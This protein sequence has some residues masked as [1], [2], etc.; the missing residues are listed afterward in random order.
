MNGFF[1]DVMG[2]PEINWGT[3]P[4]KI[5]TKTKTFQHGYYTEGEVIDETFMDVS[6]PQMLSEEEIKNKGF[7]QYADGEVYECF[8]LTEIPLN[9]NADSYRTVVF[10]NREYEIIKCSPF[11]VNYGTPQFDGYFD[12]YFAR[13]SDRQGGMNNVD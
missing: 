8:S 4:I 12:I 9:D 13:R 11:G 2:A 1:L 3:N 5:R 6:S 7:G 10:N